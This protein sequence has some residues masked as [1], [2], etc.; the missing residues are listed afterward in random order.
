M[1]KKTLILSFLV[2]FSFST[3]ILA[4]G[5]KTHAITVNPIGLVFGSFNAELNWA[6][7]PS[8]SF[9]IGGSYSSYS[10]SDWKYTLLGAEGGVRLYWTG[11]AVNK[12]YIGPLIGFT[13]I[14]AKFTEP[15]SKVTA[16]ASAS[17]INYGALVGYQ[18]IWESGFTFDFGLGVQLLTIPAVTTTISG[19]EYKNTSIS[20]TLPLIKLAIG[21][22]F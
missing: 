22:A 11:T 6:L 19:L 13:T 17:A 15:L 8:F 9:T 14:S 21:Y 3:A 20:I 2:L 7:A 16:T 12:W 18:S 4:E 10:S 1:L 5:T